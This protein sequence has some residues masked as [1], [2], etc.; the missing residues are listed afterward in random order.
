MVKYPQLQNKDW[1]VEEI[2]TKPLRKIAKEIGSSYGA[3]MY[4]ITKYQIEVPRRTKLL[5][6]PEEHSRRV[7]YA[8]KHKYPNGRFGKLA[9]HWKGG[10]K[11]LSNGYIHIYSHGHPYQTKDG[12]VMEHRLAMEKHLGRYL[13]PTED[14]HHV[15]GIRDDNRIENLEVGT[16][17]QHSK[18]HFDAVKEVEK[19]KR[20]IAELEEQVNN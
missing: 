18:K 7:R 15:N 3:V 9:S 2:K 19:L 14:V 4:M 16:R 17:K 6:N 13:L 1:L 10:R 8:L 12:Y 5:I 11:K 20:K